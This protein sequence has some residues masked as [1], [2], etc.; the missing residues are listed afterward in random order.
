MSLRVSDLQQPLPL[1]PL[2]L[3]DTHTTSAPTYFPPH[4]CRISSSMVRKALLR[5]PPIAA[6]S[7]RYKESVWW[8]V[9][10]GAQ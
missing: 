7:A 3:T 5:A 1:F 4:T 2:T 8:G 9:W 6:S 10:G